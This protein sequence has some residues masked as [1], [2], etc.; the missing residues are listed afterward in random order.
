MLMSVGLVR[1]IV[2]PAL[3]SGG[4]CALPT[5][6]PRPAGDRE[7]EA[8]HAAQK[9]ARRLPRAPDL[10]SHYRLILLLLFGHSGGDSF[11]KDCQTFVHNRIRRGQRHHDAHGVAVHATAQEQQA[12]LQG[13]V[14]GSHLSLEK[15]NSLLHNLIDLFLRL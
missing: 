6:M 15:Q 4:V 14:C 5:S 8:Q 1:G 2:T 11:F 9:K 3:V 10:S 13:V 12:A 7:R